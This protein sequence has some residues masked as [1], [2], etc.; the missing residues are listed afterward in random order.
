MPPHYLTKL[1]NPSSIAVFGASER[2][3]SVGGTAFANLLAA[4]FQGK[5]YP[6]NPKHAEIQS[7][8]CYSSLEAIDAPID[9]AVVATP[10]PTILPILHACGQKG[11]KHVVILSAGFEDAQGKVIQAQ[12]A[13][14]AHSYGMRLIG[15]NCL[16]IMRPSIGMNATFSKNQAKPGHIALVSQSGA[17]CTAVLD[18]AEANDVG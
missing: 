15:P 3:N 18:W 10:A 7:Q 9:L 16:G 5:L 1:F 12:L 2:P 8:P 4:G 6:I 11:I 17:L 14:V 13:Q